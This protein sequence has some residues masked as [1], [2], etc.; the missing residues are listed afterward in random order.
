MSYTQKHILLFSILIA[1]DLICII[2]MKHFIKDEMYSY[3]AIALVTGI[4]LS[5]TPKKHV[6]K[7]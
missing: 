3:I 4:V 5:F 7:Q 6:D 1:A 2:T